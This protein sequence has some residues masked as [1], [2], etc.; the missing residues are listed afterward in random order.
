M[1][2]F[3]DRN[4][5]T[6]QLTPV[7]RFRFQRALFRYWLL[8]ERNHQSHHILFDISLRIE[9]KSFVSSADKEEVHQFENIHA[10]IFRLSRT[11]PQGRCFLY[12][13]RTR[14]IWV[15]VTCIL[16]GFWE[17]LRPNEVLQMLDDETEWASIQESESYMAG[18]NLHLELDEIY[19]EQGMSG[20]WIGSDAPKGGMAIVVNGRLHSDTCKYSHLRGAITQFPRG[21]LQA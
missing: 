4:A 17:T 18:L 15:L 12:L 5:S 14:A 1:R 9:L 19:E 7:E 3:K 2:R 6:S 16:V 11:A 20:I 13:P 8:T 21:C 10:F